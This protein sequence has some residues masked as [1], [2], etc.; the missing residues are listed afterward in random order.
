MSFKEWLIIES[1]K[2]PGP[3]KKGLVVASIGDDDT[4]Y[5]GTPGELHSDIFSRHPNQFNKSND[6]SF[7]FAGPDGKF[8]SRA[9]AYNLVAAQR[10]V[11]ANYGNHPS[12]ELGSIQ[13]QYAQNKKPIDTTHK[14]LPKTELQIA[15]D[16]LRKAGD[17]N[18]TNQA[19]RD[20]EKFKESDIAY[21][22]NVLQENDPEEALNIL[23]NRSYRDTP[24][25]RNFIKIYVKTMFGD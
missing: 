20:R 12:H 24:E 2:D 19:L 1:A 21:I 7:G 10:K 23:T 11:S 14:T 22:S 4:I 13:L 5:Y 16:L 8:I 9:D 6:D 15:T 17:K 18:L 3:P 25:L